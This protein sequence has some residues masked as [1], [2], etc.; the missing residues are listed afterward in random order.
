MGQIIQANLQH[1]PFR[2]HIKQLYSIDQTTYQNITD[3]YK[4]L[5]QKLVYQKQRNRSTCISKKICNRIMKSI[6][7]TIEHAPIYHTSTP[8]QIF[9]HSLFQL[10][11]NGFEYLKQE[12]DQVKQLYTTLCNHPLPFENERYQSVI[13]EQIP[14]F[15][16]QYETDIYYAAYLVHDDF[17]YPL[18]DGLALYHK[19]YLKKGVDFVLTYVKRLWLEQQYI[20]CFPK[21]VVRDFIAAYEY[22]KGIEVTLLGCNLC[23]MLVLQHCLSFGIPNKHD[24]I[25]TYQE[26]EYIWQTMQVSPTMLYH[27][28]SDVINQ[29]PPTLQAYFHPHID[30]FYQH[31]QNIQSLAH[32]TNI[33]IHLQPTHETSIQLIPPCDPSIYRYFLENIQNTQDPSMIVQYFHETPLAPYDYLDVL[34][35]NLLDEITYQ[36]LFARMDDIQI[37]ILYYFAYQ[38]DLRFQ[39]QE[40]F[41]PDFLSN[42]DQEE[43]WHVYF[44][45]E[46]LSRSQEKQHMEHL[47]QQLAATTPL[48]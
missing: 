5:L 30:V 11:D 47:L 18:V 39:I 44:I 3:E 4:Q 43:E 13:H 21:E 17:D 6:D 37:A 15:L 25:L 12:V 28:I 22:Q 19:N 9:Q 40:P 14:H 27:Q 38:D 42:L 29:L 24:L 48:N 10:Y 20:L 34:S 46:L 23:E 45:R 35:S 36:R 1:I 31:F 16:S 41:D 7:F 33:G 8:T 32:L 26:L 2:S